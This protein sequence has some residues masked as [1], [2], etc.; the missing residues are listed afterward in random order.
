M[1]SDNV[2]MCVA[3]AAGD[4]ITFGHLLAKAPDALFEIRDGKIPIQHAKD[5][6]AYGAL[7]REV[8]YHDTVP[9]G[10]AVR[11]QVWSFRKHITFRRL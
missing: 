8:L 4:A 9:R 5:A 6:D 3:A 2:A 10:G 7:M 11:K 1:T